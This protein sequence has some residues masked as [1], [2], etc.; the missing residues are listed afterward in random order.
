MLR[1]ER[2][3]PTIL[4]LLA[5]CDALAESTERTN[6]IVHALAETHI[7]GKRPND[8]ILNSYVEQAENS[9]RFLERFRA[10]VAQVKRRFGCIDNR[11]FTCGAVPQMNSFRWI[12][13]GIL[14]LS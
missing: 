7:L 1:V 12:A 11:W 13:A 2:D 5:A 3:D 10:R 9:A 6:T 4:E 14:G 8:V